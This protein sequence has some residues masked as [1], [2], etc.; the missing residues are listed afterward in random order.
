MKIYRTTMKAGI[1]SI[2]IPVF[3]CLILVILSNCG[4]VKQFNLITVIL[5]DC[6]VVKRFNFK[7]VIL[8]ISGV[9][10]VN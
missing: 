1:Y 7:P 5:S 3:R 9:V 4:V 2:S 6:G 10:K 8:S